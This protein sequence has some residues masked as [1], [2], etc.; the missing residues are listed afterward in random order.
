MIHPIQGHPGWRSLLTRPAGRTRR[1]AE[2]S[3][4]R[5]QPCIE[6][7]PIVQRDLKHRRGRTQIRARAANEKPPCRQ[8]D[9]AAGLVQENQ[10]NP[11]EQLGGQ[12]DGCNAC[13]ARRGFWP[14]EKGLQ[15]RVSSTALLP[16]AIPVPHFP[17]AASLPPLLAASTLSHLMTALSQPSAT[18]APPC[19]SALKRILFFSC[20]FT[21]LPSC[22]RIELIVSSHRQKPLCCLHSVAGKDEDC[23]AVIPVCRLSAF[24]PAR[25]LFW[26]KAPSDLARQLN[27]KFDPDWKRRER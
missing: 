19:C 17:S 25:S 20:F 24:L 6:N 1:H 3:K 2:Q 9:D 8:L 5:A 22:C 12:A 16:L 15:V 13:T 10:A 26:V 11:G 14:Q 18:K 23:P 4:P 27:W 7:A 21:Q